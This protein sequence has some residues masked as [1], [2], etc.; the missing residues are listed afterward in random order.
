MDNP[1]VIRCQE[2]C[3]ALG[4][5]TLRFNFR[6][7]GHSTGSHGRGVG[8]RLDVE[9]ALAQLRTAL[10]ATDAMAVIGYSFGAAVVAQVAADGRRLAGLG[11]IAPPLALE[12]FALPPGL[13]TLSGSILVVGGTQDQYCS[14]P[15]LRTVSERFPNTQVRI[16]EGANHFFF[17]K[18]FALG[19]VVAAWARS[20]FGLQTREPGWGGGAG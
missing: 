19:E 17:G 13:A 9:G 1:V 3:A 2:V 12:G 15:A 10:T 4:L 16:V 8:E 5:A 14:L 18:L 20:V 11:L 6:G 7:V